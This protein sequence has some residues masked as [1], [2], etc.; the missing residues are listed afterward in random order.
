MN[1]NSQ[2]NEPR[3]DLVNQESTE[4]NLG[5]DLG[6]LTNQNWLFIKHF[7]ESADIRTAYQLAG[8]ES[9][10]PSA[11]YQVF[12]RLKPYIEEIGNLGVTSR[13]K[14]VA[15]L[16]KVLALPL[17]EKQSL[18]VSEWLRVRKFAATLT[19][20]VNQEKPKLSVLIINRAMPAASAEPLKVDN[21]TPPTDNNPTP[22]LTPNNFTDAE[23][24]E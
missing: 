23:I 6:K 8:Y 22:T 1:E 17:V 15:D 4:K 5:L 14:L 19:P 16:S 18:T 20:E 24:V 2:N 11:P 21:G 9:K 10:E 13:L 3:A 7:L 12:K